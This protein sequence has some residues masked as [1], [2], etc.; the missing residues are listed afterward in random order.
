[1]KLKDTKAEFISAWGAIAPNWGI[2]RTMGEIHALLFVSTKPMNVDEIM[3]ELNIARANTGA[4]LKE[5]VS[6]GIVEKR[7]FKDER[8]EF[9]EADKNLL[10]VTTL[11]IRERRKRELEPLLRLLENTNLA[12]ENNLD[13]KHFNHS[14]EQLKSFA[15]KIDR[16][17]IS[18]ELKEKSVLFSLLRSLL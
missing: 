13:A 8:R 16:M 5:L 9:F 15:Q 2:N 17:M 11:I 7:N 12:Q 14:V 6:I 1:M 18:V 3:E 10:R 4:C